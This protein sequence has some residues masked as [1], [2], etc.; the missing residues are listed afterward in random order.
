MFSQPSKP[1]MTWFLLTPKCIP[2]FM[3]RLSLPSGRISRQLPR[4]T[5]AAE[6]LLDASDYSR[7]R[8]MFN[9]RRISSPVLPSRARSESATDQGPGAGNPAGRRPQPKPWLT[10][11]VD[12]QAGA[13]PGRAV[14]QTLGTPGRA[15][16]PFAPGRAAN[17]RPTAPQIADC[18]ERRRRALGP[19][20]AARA[21]LQEP[22]KQAV[23]TVHRPPS[24][25]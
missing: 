3:A 19:E 6:Q 13:G 4:C 8:Q 11:A 14:R 10:A 16:R 24:T 7:A 15:G 17:V 21:R 20:S 23:Y 18:G 22:C 5:T 1:K 25:V 2:S 12:A 9:P